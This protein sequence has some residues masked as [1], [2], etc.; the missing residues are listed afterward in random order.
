MSTQHS[1]NSIIKEVFP[2][3]DPTI[4]AHR[5]RAEKLLKA[6]QKMDD[7]ISNEAIDDFFTH[8]TTEEQFFS[9]YEK[10]KNLMRIIEGD[11]ED[12]DQNQM[13]IIYATDDELYSFGQYYTEKFIDYI[14]KNIQDNNWSN[15]SVFIKY[16]QKL[17]SYD[18]ISY[19][20]EQLDDRNHTILPVLSQP[21]RYNELMQYKYPVMKEFYTLQSDLDGIYFEDEI[22]DINN[23]VADN[24]K[25][26]SK[27][28]AIL[29]RILFAL[30]H[31]ETDDIELKTLLEKNGKI[32][33]KWAKLATDSDLSSNTL[34][35]KPQKSSKE[36]DESLNN[37]SEWIMMTIY[38]TVVGFLIYKGFDWLNGTMINILI[39]EAILFLIF[40]KSLRK[41]YEE[42]SK[43]KEAKSF[44]LRMKKICFMSLML[45]FYILI[46]ALV[47]GLIVAA[48][49]LVIVTKGVGLVI[50]Y[51]LY[52]WL[53]K[54]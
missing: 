34:N 38:L 19:L 8:L 28:K 25:T 48:I 6:R 27:N 23:Q 14:R 52:R 9:G 3:F 49:G 24:Q 37:K 17:L 42:N 31:F 33:A 46:I 54:K 26:S 53:R 29:G 50:I 45:Q 21:E 41:R 7:S 18:A 1:L 16:Y 10:D 5:I 44:K 15:L 30:S 40:Y 39:G 32:G 2:D 4:E 20:K 36:E 22:N 35:D 51:L 13:Y 11:Y 43:S 12:I 47:I